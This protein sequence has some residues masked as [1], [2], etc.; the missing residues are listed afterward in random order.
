MGN[1]DS[2]I[3][4][5]IIVYQQTLL[6]TTTGNTFLVMLFVCYRK[7]ESAIVLNFALDKKANTYTHIIGH[8]HDYQPLYTKMGLHTLLS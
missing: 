2:L 7:Y 6:T 1:K 5:I 4:P 8:L 3:R